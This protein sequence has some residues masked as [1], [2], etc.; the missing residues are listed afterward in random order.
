M[1]FLHAHTPYRFLC[2]KCVNNTETGTC[3]FTRPLQNAVYTFVI[4]LKGFN[5]YI[6]NTILISIQ[7]VCSI[8]RY[9]I[10]CTQYNYLIHI[11]LYTTMN[12]MYLH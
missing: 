11:S 3:T 7:Q 4:K 1:E 8:C 2:N 6:T 10:L 5:N 12:W 9:T